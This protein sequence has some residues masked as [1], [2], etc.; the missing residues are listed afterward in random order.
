MLPLTVSLSFTE[1][2]SAEGLRCLFEVALAKGLLF[3]AASIS[4]LRDEELEG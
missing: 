1:S 3:A 2:S 4:C